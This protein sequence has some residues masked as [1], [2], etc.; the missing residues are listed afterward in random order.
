M[1]LYS[2]PDFVLGNSSARFMSCSANHVSDNS[3][4][5]S[6]RAPENYVPQAPQMESTE[7]DG[8]SAEVY[9]LPG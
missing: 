6:Q 8:R 7:A 9:E 4:V 1:S 2:S 5:R 3:T